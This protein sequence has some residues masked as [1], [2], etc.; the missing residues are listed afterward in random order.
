ML[1]TPNYPPGDKEGI[2]TRGQGGDIHQ[3]TR[4]GY[5]PGDKEGIFTR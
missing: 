2:S 4:R 3:G 5:S 1:A